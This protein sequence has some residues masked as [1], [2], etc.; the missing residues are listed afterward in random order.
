[1]IP[2]PIILF[3]NVFICQLAHLCNRLVCI[4]SDS[5]K[6][7]GFPCLIS[8]DHYP[9]NALI[10]NLC[11][12]F[13]LNSNILPY[14]PIVIRIA[15]LLSSLERHCSFLDSDMSP[16]LTCLMTLNRFGECQFPVNIPSLQSTID[17]RLFPLLDDPPIVADY[18]CPLLLHDLAP[19]AH[20]QWDKT[21]QRILPFVNG[22][23]SCQKISLVTQINPIFTKAAVQ[24]L[25]YY[26]CATL[27]NVFQ[28]S[29]YYRC[30]PLSKLLSN[31]ELIEECIQFISIPMSNPITT[32]Q[33]CSLFCMI[34]GGMQ[35]SQWV[36]QN[37]YLVQQIDPR[38]FFLFGVIKGFLVRL[39]KYPILLKD[40]DLPNQMHLYFNGSHH[41][42]DICTR[43]S[44]SSNELDKLLANI[45][46]HILM[47]P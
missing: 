22:L 12:V 37:S 10:F 9:R 2:F 1:L 13:D 47:K 15:T 43:F 25:V 42:D 7:V 31:P 33:L 24:H 5:Y 23:N 40:L 16:F 35:A 46:V 44:I 4:S 45:P 34:G 39:H 38:R 11:L 28:F 26:K 20:H 27:V 21:V 14:Y 19:L 41:F 30:M 36:S 32:G 8:G 17:I 3:Q 29:N 6:I 18:H